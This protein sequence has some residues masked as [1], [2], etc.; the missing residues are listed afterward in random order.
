MTRANVLL[1][2]AAPRRRGSARWPTRWSATRRTS[3]RSTRSRRWGC[4]PPSTRTRATRRRSPT[5]APTRWPST[6]SRCGTPRRATS[7]TTCGRSP[8]TR[9][10]GAPRWRSRQRRG[11]WRWPAAEPRTGAR[12]R[13][14]S[15][16]CAS[17]KRVDEA[18]AAARAVV[19][20]APPAA[21]HLDLARCLLAADKNDEANAE[22]DRAIAADPGDLMALDLR[23]WPAER[24]D[25][26]Q[27]QAAMPKLEAHAEAHPGERRRVADARARAARASATPRRPWP[28]FEKAVALAPADDDLRA[29]W[30]AELVRHGK[31]AAVIAD[32]EKLGDMKTPRLES[33]LEPRRG[34][35]RGGAQDGGAG[36]LRRNQPRRVAARRRPQARQARRDGRGRERSVTTFSSRSSVDLSPNPLARGAGAR[37]G[38]VRDRCST[39]PSRTRRARGSRT[40]ARPI[41][42]ALARP[43]RSST[44]PPRSASRRRARRSAAR[45]VG[46]RAGVD[47]V[48]RRADGEHERGVRLPLQA[49]AAIRATRCSSRAELSALRAP[50]APRER[51]RR[52]LPARL[53]RR[54]AR[55]PRLARSDAVT[56]RTRAVVTVSPN[57]PTGSYLKRAE[58]AGARPRWGSPS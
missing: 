2:L 18:T 5:C 41:L 7:T 54:V 16:R 58:L 33:A 3:R 22:L 44:S 45:P 8:I 19:E 14:G 24:H 32:A 9:W 31:A 35:R 53:R 57:N 29:E 43:R 13:R 20:K 23:W 1:A 25:L 17:S 10:S 49:A 46:A 36:G 52:S 56:P 48:A 30:W 26:E 15:P 28:L 42:A 27:L 4:S 51:A 12:S 37:A 21:A 34:L 47:R 55:R 39:S 50:G 11:P 6:W 38:G 40:R